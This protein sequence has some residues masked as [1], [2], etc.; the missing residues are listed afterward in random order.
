M[1]Q[2][3]LAG[4]THCVQT[5]E[6][7]MPDITSNLTDRGQSAAN[8]GMVIRQREPVNFEYP[9]DQLD[10]FL[11]PSNLFYIRSHFKA[12]II[13]T[14]SYRAQSG[15]SRCDPMTFRYE[16]LRAMPSETRV[17]HARMRRQQPDLSRSASGRR[18]MAI[19]RRG[20]C[21]MDR[22][23]ARY[24]LE[25]AGLSED[26]TEIV[27]EGQ[28]AAR[29]GEADSAGTDLVCQKPVACESAFF[30]S[31][32]GLSDERP[33][34][35]AKSWLSYEADCAWALRDGLGEMADRDT[36][37]SREDF[38]GTGRLPITPIGGTWTGSLSE[39]HLPTW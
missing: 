32:G 12:P 38:K 21:R 1:T 18:A 30:R 23:S 9:F 10:A 13:E 31:A 34:S 37:G 22:G 27:F 19:R 25:R 36:R 8:V 14:S 35:A 17:R 5:E 29:Q 15:R 20:Q 6:E 24:L 3:K 39:C 2:D 7:P 26:A 33:G 4:S 28:I 16:D 11:T